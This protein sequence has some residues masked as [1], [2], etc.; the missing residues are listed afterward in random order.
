ML[1]PVLWGREGPSRTQAG[2][3]AHILQQSQE[4]SQPPA[5]TDN[6]RR[7][8][9]VVPPSAG[10]EA[11]VV[12]TGLHN[13]GLSS[14]SEDSCSFCSLKWVQIASLMIAVGS[15]LP[16]LSEGPLIKSERAWRW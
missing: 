3:L 5:G 4:Q 6:P 15:H 10:K 9:T 1:P 13:S 16:L 8:C 14:G 2:S 12:V 11:E 7:G